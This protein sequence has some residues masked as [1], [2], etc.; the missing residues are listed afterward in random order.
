[1]SEFQYV[2]FRAID[3]PLT[4][5]Q[6][7]FM[8]RQSSRAKITRWTFD[9]TYHFGDFHGDADKMLRRGY[10]IHVHYANF[11]IRK[12]SIRLPQG[13]PIPKAQR[14]AF[15][16]GEVVVWQPDSKGAA[17]ILTISPDLDAG[18]GDD[19]WDVDQYLD[20]IVD[21]RQQL[22]DGDLRP[23]YVG[24]LCACHSGILDASTTIE[25]PVP[26]G[27]ADVPDSTEALMEFLNID[28]LTLTAAAEHSP[29]LAPVADPKEAMVEWL[30]SVDT[31]TVRSWLLSFLAGDSVATK[32][33][34]LKRFRDS[35]PANL[36]PTVEGTRTFAELLRRIETLQ[37]ENRRRAKKREERVRKKRRADIAKSPQKYLQEVDQHVATRSGKGYEHAAKLL[38]EIREAIGGKNGDELACGY[39]TELSKN[40]P[41]L[42]MLTGALRHQGLL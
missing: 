29:P 9:N 37:E 11:G 39:A 18:Y 19:L 22:I 41:T 32:T 40:H 17:G 5:T 13:L 27:L 15:L 31:T 28:P 8:D 42:R 24:W 23:L 36:W 21:V 2:G 26:A 20:R 14:P 35:S 12:I 4:D 3:A 16:D 30:R 1:M 33:E 10:D 6:L 34:C 38:S 7:R 25:P